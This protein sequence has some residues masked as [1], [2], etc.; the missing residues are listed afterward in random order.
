MDQRQGT[1]KWIALRRDLLEE[2][3]ETERVYTHGEKEIERES[4]NKNKKESIDPKK[5]GK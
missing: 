4:K 3:S 5:E 2:Y 1:C